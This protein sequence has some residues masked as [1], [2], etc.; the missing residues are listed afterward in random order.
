MVRLRSG[1]ASTE[2]FDACQRWR[3]ASPEHERAWSRLDGVNQQFKT[4]PGELVHATFERA[5]A[6]RRRVSRRTVLKSVALVAGVGTLSLAAQH[7][8]RRFWHGATA[9]HRTA[10]GEQRLLALVDGGSVRLNTATALDLRLADQ[11]ACIDLWQ[12]EVLVHCVRELAVRTAHG[13]VSAQGGSRFSVRQMEDGHSTQVQVL[14]GQVEAL[15]QGQSQAVRVSKG[16]QLRFSSQEAPAT[17]AVQ[18]ANA[19]AL[20]WVDGVLVARQMRLA[21]FV[22]ELGRYRAGWLR[23]AEDAM[24]LRLSG[25][26]PLADPERVLAAVERTLPV[27]SRRLSRYWVTLQRV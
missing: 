16:E 14:D 10:T 7:P 12:G 21:D 27:R 3:Q 25:V 9:A 19:D 1:L 15:A 5:A 24:A 2:E 22:A 4:L 13:L 18:P 17:D 8:A 6:A 20:S 11:P 23:C 26:F